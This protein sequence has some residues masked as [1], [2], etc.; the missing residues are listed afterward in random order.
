MELHCKV[1][2]DFEMTVLEA[3]EKRWACRAYADKDVEAEK[4]HRI[5]RAGYLAPTAKNEQRNKLIAV[6]DPDL[7]GRLVAACRGQKFVGEAP[8]VLVACANDERTMICGQ[9]ARSMDCAIAMS[10]MRLQA[11]EE[12]L[13]GCWLGWYDPEQVR[14]VLNIPLDYVVVS[15]MP[16]GYPAKEGQ[17][18]P[19]KPMEEIVVYNRMGE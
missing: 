17:R 12:G 2:G 11:I 5:M 18:S 7:R 4:L 13:Q 9:S 10:F 8:V 3:V 15:V 16:I 1:K 19:K 14:K 6:T